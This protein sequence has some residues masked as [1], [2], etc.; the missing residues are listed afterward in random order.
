MAAILVYLAIIQIPGNIFT[1]YSSETIFISAQHLHF[2]EMSPGQEYH[3]RH[4][5]ASTM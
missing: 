1:G 5:T 4:L 2:Q 3:N